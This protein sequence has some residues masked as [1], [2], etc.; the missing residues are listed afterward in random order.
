MSF[1]LGEVTVYKDE[2]ACEEAEE[3]EGTRL[4]L[5]QGN[6]VVATGGGTPRFNLYSQSDE[7]WQQMPMGWSF[8]LSTES[9]QQWLFGFSGN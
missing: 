9:Q 7:I 1:E 6:E 4:R 8:L 5:A 3:L 2:G